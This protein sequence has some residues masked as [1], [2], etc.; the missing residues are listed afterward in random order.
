[1][2]LPV[3]AFNCSTTTIIQDCLRQCKIKTQTKALWS[4]FILPRI[5]FSSHVSAYL[6]NARF[7]NCLDSRLLW[8]SV[9]LFLRYVF[10]KLITHHMIPTRN[11]MQQV[12]ST[13]NTKFSK[14]KLKKENLENLLTNIHFKTW[15]RTSS[16][17]SG[18]SIHPIGCPSDLMSQRIF[19]CL[20]QGWETWR[21][22]ALHQTNFKKSSCP[23]Y[24]NHN[25]ETFW[26][27][28]LK[29]KLWFVLEMWQTVEL[30]LVRCS[31]YL[32][33]QMTFFNISLNYW[34]QLILR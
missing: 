5:L 28:D 17:K 21:R 19:Y 13:V 18:F 30:M 12:I 6:I 8:T 11:A 16:R 1:M 20:L 2:L 34:W 7:Y 10:P 27:P 22:E 26:A 24:H 15:S 25:A 33:I 29:S 32:Y 3:S 4:V 23:L 14:K 9:M 31:V